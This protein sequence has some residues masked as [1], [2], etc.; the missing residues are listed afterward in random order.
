[1]AIRSWRSDRPPKLGDLVHEDPWELERGFLV[2]GVEERSR[3]DIWYV[4]LERLTWDEFTA[5]AA[6]SED[7]ESGGKTWCFVR[8][9]R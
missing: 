3:P 5:L 6:A 9:R 8:D 7:I 1:M 4:L 2:V